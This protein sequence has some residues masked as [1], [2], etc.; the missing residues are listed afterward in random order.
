MQIKMARKRMGRRRTRKA[1]YKKRRNGIRRRSKRVKRAMGLSRLRPFSGFPGRKLCKFTYARRVFLDPVEPSTIATYQ[2]HAN[3][4]YNPDFTAPASD[5]QPRGWDQWEPF[6][7]HYIVIGSKINVKL[8]MNNP[9]STYNKP[10]VAGVRLVDA[11]GS[12]TLTPNTWEWLRENGYNMKMWL[13]NENDTRPLRISAGYSPKKFFN[14]KDLKDNITR[15]G[16]QQGALPSE[17]AIFQI[18]L[19][20]VNGDQIP[21]Q[22]VLALVTI[23][24]LVM[25]SEPKRLNVS[26]I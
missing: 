17:D 23:D 14:V 15:L 25:F 7:D 18:W 20:T 2:F 5:H 9:V 22:S 1:S 21:G 24:Y 11:A 8:M 19:G 12:G 10:L 6:Y 13:P 3:G 4:P 26:S 16:A